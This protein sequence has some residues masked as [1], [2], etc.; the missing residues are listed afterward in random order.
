MGIFDMLD[1]E[2]KVPLPSIEKFTSNVINTCKSN[3]TLLTLPNA[4]TN[5]SFLIRHFAA[6]VCYDTVINHFPF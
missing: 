2:S 6:D 1:D 5:E 3:K 4:D